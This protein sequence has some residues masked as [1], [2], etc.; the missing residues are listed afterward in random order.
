MKFICEQHHSKREADILCNEFE[1]Y[2]FKFITISFMGNEL[3]GGLSAPSPSWRNVHAACNLNHRL[4][5][6]YIYTWKR[7]SSRDYN[8]QHKYLS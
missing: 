1:K 5:V 4:N 6:E 7:M 8:I 3:N 2:V